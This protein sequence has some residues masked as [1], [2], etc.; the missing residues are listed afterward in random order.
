[1]PHPST[2]T[3]PAD[4]GILFKN[5]LPTIN[6]KVT[7]SPQSSAVPGRGKDCQVVRS[8]SQ[9]R[10]AIVHQGRLQVVTF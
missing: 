4:P 6:G 3:R 8:V 5:P 2:R 7:M 9:I 10:S 1:M